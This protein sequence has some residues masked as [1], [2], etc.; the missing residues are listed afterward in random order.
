MNPSNH[1]SIQSSIRSTSHLW[2]WLSIQSAIYENRHP[3]IL[4]SIQPVSF[5]L[6]IIPAINLSSHQSILPS[7][8]SYS[9]PSIHIAFQPAIHHPSILI[10]PLINSAIRICNQ[11]L[12]DAA[13]FQAVHPSD[14]LAIHASIQLSTVP[15]VHPSSQSFKH[16][17]IHPAILTIS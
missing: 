10:R 11:S 14:H 7:R 4:P 15:S 12:F 6:T 17:L 16:P 3:S 13:P 8:Q 9:Q 5:Q 1:K 2:A